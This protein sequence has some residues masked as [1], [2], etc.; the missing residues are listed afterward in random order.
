[1]LLIVVITFALSFISGIVFAAGA[2]GGAFQAGADGVDE[3]QIQADMMHNM[4][5]SLGTQ[6]WIG[7]GISII[8]LA[9]LT[10]PALA[11]IYGYVA[12]GEALGALD[13]LGMAMLGA[14]L[15][16]ARARTG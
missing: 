5:G 12:F 4:A 6:A 8:G 10:Q 16:V 7:V 14:A 3:A 11:A 15:A 13:I 9:L 1:M 2:M